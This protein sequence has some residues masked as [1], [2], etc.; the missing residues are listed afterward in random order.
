MQ[1][2]NERIRPFLFRMIFSPLQRF[3]AQQNDIRTEQAPDATAHIR[4]SRHRYTP[5]SLSV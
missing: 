1:K 3:R 2:R 5:L 4:S